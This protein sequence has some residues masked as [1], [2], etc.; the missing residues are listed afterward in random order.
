LKTTPE[1]YN[2]I[3]TA[4]KPKDVIGRHANHISLFEQ[5]EILEYEIIYFLSK[6]P[7]KDAK[8]ESNLG[9]DDDKGRYICGAHDHVAYRYEILEE[10]GKGSF[11]HVYRA[12][13]HKHKCHVALKIIRN[14]KTPNSQARI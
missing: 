10:L 9:F 2:L 4:S 11:G 13:D 8:G 14:K 5:A 12:V 3:T 7:P 6:N 1:S